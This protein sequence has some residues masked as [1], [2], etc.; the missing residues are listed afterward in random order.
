MT[1]VGSR[2][3]GFPNYVSAPALAVVAAGLVYLVFKQK[4]AS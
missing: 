2:L 3:D 1:T 4:G